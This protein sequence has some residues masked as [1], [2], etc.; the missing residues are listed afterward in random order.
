MNRHAQAL[1]MFLL[2]VAVLHAGYTPLYARYVK[3]GLR[4]L[5]LAAGAV[6]IVTA[7]ATVW[8]SR[9]G[10]P[11]HE[12]HEAHGHGHGGPRIGWLLTLPFLALLLVAPPSL[13]AYSAD[14]TGTA[15][16]PPPGFTALPASGPLRLGL[17]DYAGRAVYDHG[18][19]LAGRSITITGF[20]SLED[21]AAYLTRMVLNCCAADAQPVKVGLSGTLPP[22]LRSDTWL[23][24]TGSYVAEQAK[25]PVN[26]APIPYLN[27]SQARPV[28]TPKDPYES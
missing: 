2:G 12:G 28:P 21:G 18:R 22:V 26:G 19:L 16:A 13:G 6:L 7:L 1:V 17:V 3:S 27:V 20:I 9:R 15:L 8:T 23:E 24:V 5:L 14:R 11:V 4:P 10:R 25:D